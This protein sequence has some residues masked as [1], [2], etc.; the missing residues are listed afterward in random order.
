MTTGTVL[1]TAAHLVLFLYTRIK[2]VRKFKKATKE[3]AHFEVEN[4]QLRSKL[5]TL[6]SIIN[7]YE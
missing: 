5:E 6:E 1:F 3:K 7:A 4:I 2:Y